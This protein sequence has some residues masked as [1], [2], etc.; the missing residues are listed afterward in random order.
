MSSYK[1]IFMHKMRYL[2]MVVGF[3]K[4]VNPFNCNNLLLYVLIIKINSVMNMQ[5]E[6]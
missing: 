6:R 1:Y 3:K 4:D 5:G 2:F